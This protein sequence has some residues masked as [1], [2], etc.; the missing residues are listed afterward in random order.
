MEASLLKKNQSIELT[1]EDL[2]HDGSGVGKIDGY[3]LF[4]PNTLPGEKVTAKII[5]LNKNY[6]FARMETIESVSADRV[7]PPCAVYSKCGG[8]SLQH[9]SYDGQLAFKRNQVEETMKRIGKLKVDVPETLGMENP[10][11]YRN[12]SQV[13]VGFVNGKL[14][15]GFYQKRSHAIIDMSTCLIHNE[16]GDFAVQKTREILAK[17]GTEP[18]D[19]KTGKGDIRHIMTRFAHTTGQIMLVLVTT[20]ER[21]PFKNEIVQDLVEQLE[22]TSIVQNINPHKTNVIFGDRTKTLWG[23]D[24]IEDTIHGIR[25]AISA[26]SFYQV[27]PLQTEVLYQQAI[28][29]AELTGE[30]TVIDAYCGIGSI[31]LCLAKKAKH[32]YGVEIVDQAIQ[33]A[34]AN[35]ELNELTNTTFETGKAEEVIPAWYKAGIEAD[36]LVVDPPRKGC[37]EKLLE[38]ILAMKPK[39]VVYVSCNPGTLAR[40]MKILTDGG[41]VAKK[42]Q[43]VDMFPMTTHIEAVTVLH[44]N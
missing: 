5:K 36:V 7:E 9:L 37:D 25:F 43:P 14:T 18:Y 30:E 38:T 3:P 32:V 35:A 44:L 15:A 17:Y 40:D 8:C 1:I 27:N 10:W 19:E 21:M 13:P 28:D 12:K 33:D 16:Q 2:T 42:V 24:I 26:R 23:K 29:A 34:R 11:R 4:I 41:Y 39:K 6:G 31:S 22:L 20:K